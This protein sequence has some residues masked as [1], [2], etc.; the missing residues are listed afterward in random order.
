[1]TAEGI[2]V[3]IVLSSVQPVLGKDI[4]TNHRI[5]FLTSLHGWCCHQNFVVLFFFFYSTKWPL[6]HQVCGHW[7]GF[8]FL[9]EGEGSLGKSWRGSLGGL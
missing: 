4:G 6:W 9:K 5:M 7:M 1:M 2:N 8:S 3:Q